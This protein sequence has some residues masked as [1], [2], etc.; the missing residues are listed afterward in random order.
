MRWR[1][2]LL[3]LLAAAPG[4]VRGEDPPEDRIPEHVSRLRSGTWNERMHAVYAL[5]DIGA[6]AVPALRLAAEDIDWQIRLTAVHWL[7][8][9]GPAAIPA[10]AG[11]LMDE[12]CRLVRVTAVHWLG[13][14][15]GP[16]AWVLEEGSK[17]ESGMVR[18]YGRYW[19]RRYRREAEHTAVQEMPELV[20]AAR[21]DLLQCVSSNAPGLLHGYKVE[22]LDEMA[23][24]PDAYAAAM[25]ASAGEM[26]PEKN[27]VSD[28]VVGM[29]KEFA[30]TME[31]RQKALDRLAP[32]YLAPAPRE[33]SMEPDRIVGKDWAPST[34][35]KATLAYLKRSEG[36]PPK[37]KTLPAKEGPLLAM[38][39]RPS[40]AQAFPGAAAIPRPAH[41]PPN[42][43]APA[44]AGA[45]SPVLSRPPAPSGE[46]LPEAS[47]GPSRGAPEPQPERAP[48]LPLRP[49]PTLELAGSIDGPQR[50]LAPTELKISR[51]PPPSPPP[52]APKENAPRPEPTAAVAP[53][54]EGEKETLVPRA[55]LPARPAS[56]Q[57][58]PETARAPRAYDEPLLIARAPTGDRGALAA[59]A[60]P[61]RAGP[62]PAPPPETAPVPRKD[63]AP[64]LEARA[65]TGERTVLAAA[66]PIPKPSSAIAPAELR[67]EKGGKTKIIYEALVDL[68]AALDS[69]DAKQRALAT[70]E[71]GAMGRKAEPALQGL[72]KLLRK[73]KDRKVRAG[74]A[75]ALG[76][77]GVNRTEVV[78]ALARALDDR[79]ADVEYSAAEA[80]GRIRSQDARSVFQKHERQSADRLLTR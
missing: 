80:L 19:L 25:T 16:A 10:L 4:P 68:I 9:N 34:L 58:G 33:H 73:D 50:I 13:A 66:P 59:V 3:C 26:P 32:D 54:I 43:E 69:P 40:G 45:A 5:G 15:G 61:T 20:R 47:P 44:R 46:A 38:A 12:P 27:F 70:Y 8:R 41:V 28:Q 14:I 62:S 22:T 52:E 48:S 7:G 77:I 75:L 11:V 63:P 51:S 64:A 74:A 23:G 18:I 49:E 65:D 71:L 60:P 31:A 55:P 37:A 78:D 36:E 53:R 2:V 6:P 1:G 17:D 72:V 24:E 42:F 79:D 57:A 67:L 35:P 39:P 29:I 21:E 76:N 56:E 30:V